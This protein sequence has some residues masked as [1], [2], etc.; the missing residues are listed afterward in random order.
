MEIQITPVI[1]VELQKATKIWNKIAEFAIND[2]LNEDEYEEDFD[3]EEQDDL[4]GN[5]FGGSLA[6]RSDD[7]KQFQREYMQMDVDSFLQI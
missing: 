5:Y 1:H 2:Y 7:H 3:H 6:Y 4:I